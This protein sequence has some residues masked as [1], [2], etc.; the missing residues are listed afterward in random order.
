MTTPLDIIN[1]ALK[2]SGAFGVGQTPLAEDVNDAFT[3]LNWMLAQW[4]RK[5]WL[6][7][8]LLDLSVLSTGA[9]SYT[10]GPGGDINTS[11]RPDRL[12]KAYF[13]QLLNSTPNQVDYPLQVI[14]SREEYSQITLKSLQSFPS[15]IF[16][17]SDFPTGKIFP[18]PLPQAG[19]Y[20]IH[21]LI[22]MVLGEF[23]SLTQDIILPAEYM[24]AIHFN[25]TQRLCPTYGLPVPQEVKSQALWSLGVI[26]GAN[27]QIGQLTMPQGIPRANRY[28][29]YSDQI[30]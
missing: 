10:V 20:E 28:N 3:R 11:P 12:E 21:I 16:Y 14:Q 7:Y 6:V 22:K 15:W 1:L 13:R 4:N 25:L 29:P 26:R 27:T 5:R 30:K 24:A 9:Q 23:T 18:W 2:D 17:D 8:H 19:I